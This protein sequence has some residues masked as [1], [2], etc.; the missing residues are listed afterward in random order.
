MIRHGLFIAG[1]DTGV[2]KTLVGSALL[3]AAHRRGRRLVPFKPAETGADPEPRDAH[4]LHRAAGAPVPIDRVCLYAFPLPAAPQAAAT[5]AGVAISLAAILERAHDLASAGDG[6]LVE[7][8]GG[9][10]VPYAP[11]FTGADLA[12]RLR[13]PV[14]L[15]GRSG[16]GTINH[17]ALSVHE[18]RRRNLEIAGI[19]LV[20]TGIERQPHEETN[21]PL[22]A[23][24]TGISP[25]GVVPHLPD[26]TNAD[27]LADALLEA[28]GPE[29]LDRLLATAT[30]R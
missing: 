30:G 12:A 3:R 13:L 6:L 10:L 23:H 2:G 17:T 20:Q 15:V 9:L 4:A 28:I 25:L 14:L 16:L 26:P 29:A 7:A 11:D 21:A 22:I 1:T 5:Q 27:R 18:L 19:V 8:A 24:L